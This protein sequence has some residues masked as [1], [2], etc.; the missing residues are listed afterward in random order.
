M[1]GPGVG[2]G[3]MDMAWGT[4]DM[5]G[6]HGCTWQTSHPWEAVAHA[7][8]LSTVLPWASNT[9][10]LVVPVARALVCPEDLAYSPPE[11]HRGPEGPSL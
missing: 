6:G 7:S 10:T 4:Q 8:E 11:G 9:G 5:A 2:E 3:D 1:Q